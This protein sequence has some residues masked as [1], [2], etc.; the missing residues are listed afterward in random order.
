MKTEGSSVFLY[1]NY[2]YSIEAS[3]YID[4]IKGHF[5]RIKIPEGNSTGLRLVIERVKR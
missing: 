3:D 4:E 2:D 5:Q 1:G